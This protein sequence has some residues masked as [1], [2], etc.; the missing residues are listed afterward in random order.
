M[1]DKE[2]SLRLG[3]KGVE[4]PAVCGDLSTEFHSSL[5][6]MNIFHCTELEFKIARG[7]PVRELP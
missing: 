6:V 3:L 1:K 5:A 7:R 4:N 2:G